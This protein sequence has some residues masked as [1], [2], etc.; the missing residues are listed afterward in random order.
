MAN[1]SD[2][3]KENAYEDDNDGGD[4]EEDGEGSISIGIASALS[5]S[6]RV[7]T[8]GSGDQA[9]LTFSVE[10]R[11]GPCNGGVIFHRRA[12]SEHNTPSKKNMGTSTTSP[13]PAPLNFAL[14]GR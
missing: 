5:L 10:G 8:N 6:K 2:D 7:S 13:T 1:G 12:R 14:D 4:D 11:G 3:G 9:V